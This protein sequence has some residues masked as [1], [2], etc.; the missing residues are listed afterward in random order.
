M[1]GLK[2]SLLNAS[3]QLPMDVFSMLTSCVTATSFENSGAIAPGYQADLLI[4]DYLQSISI[5]KV[6]K[7][8]KCVVENREINK[9]VFERSGNDKEL[10]LNLPKINMKKLQKT[11]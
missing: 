6:I 10:A 5:D 8:G 4:L 3:E 11:I 2:L 9:E 1:G 7:K